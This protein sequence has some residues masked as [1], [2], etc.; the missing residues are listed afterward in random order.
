M[1]RR[2]FA[3]L[4]AAVVLLAAVPLQARAASDVCFVSI[5]DTLPETIPF[6]YLRSSVVYIPSSALSSFRIYTLYDANIA[7]V[8]VYTSSQQVTIDMNTGTATDRD[9]MEY[10]ATAIYRNG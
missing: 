1:K 6:A 7:T 8:L 3:L 4:L 2:L 9:G 10:S 5:N